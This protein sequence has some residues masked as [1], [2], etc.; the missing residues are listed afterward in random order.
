MAEVQLLLAFLKAK[1]FSL[2][3]FF[4]VFGMV[5]DNFSMIAPVRSLDMESDFSVNRLCSCVHIK[6]L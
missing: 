6:V 4:G 5:L 3:K 2:G 1:F